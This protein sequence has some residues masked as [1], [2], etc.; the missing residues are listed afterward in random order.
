MTPR[1]PSNCRLKHCCDGTLDI[2]LAKVPLVT[3]P[4]EASPSPPK[5]FAEKM[6]ERAGFC[7]S[8]AQSQYG[9]VTEESMDLNADSNCNKNSRCHKKNRG[10]DMG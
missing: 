1:P 7:E 9:S 2:Q 10:C 8:N 3:H 4:V 5:A 6:G